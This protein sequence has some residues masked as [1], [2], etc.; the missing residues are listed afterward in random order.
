MSND[1]AIAAVTLTLR[2]LLIDEIRRDPPAPI[3]LNK[4][5]DITTLAP[6]KLGLAGANNQINVFL[7][8]THPN[9]AWRNI[10]LPRTRGGEAGRPPLAIDLEYIV[11][12]YGE[13]DSEV[14]SHYLLGTA[15]RVLHDNAVLAR[16]RIRLPESGLP[17]QVERVTITQ[18]PLGIDDL[19]KLWSSFTGPYRASATY[20]ATVILIESINPTRAGLPVLRRGSE[21][22]GPVASTAFPPYLKRTVPL[23]R[24]PAARLGDDFAIDGKNLSSDDI[25]IFVHSPRLPGPIELAPLAGATPA[26]VTAHIPNDANAVDEWAAGMLTVSLSLKR[27]DVPV[28]PTNE[29]SLAVAPII[30]VAPLNANIANPPVDIAFTVTCKPRLHAGQ[31]V[32]LLFGDAPQV[33]PAAPP[34]PPANPGDPSTITF[35]VTPS[36]PGQYVVR[37]RVDGVD[38]IAGEIDANGNLQFAANQTVTII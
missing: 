36:Q 24:F 3:V 8:A 38:S 19:S 1:F 33:A 10:D 37:L 14:V 28:W 7:Y 34:V 5:I 22:R 26:R 35:N 11:S 4:D 32:F 31:Q 13:D 30:A 12:A 2:D 18:K 17:E 20:L 9:G 6:S 25:K 21:D 29:V 23:T 15:M 27:D 16:D